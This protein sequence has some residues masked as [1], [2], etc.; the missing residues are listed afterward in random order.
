MLRPQVINLWLR[1]TPLLNKKG[2]S[3]DPQTDPYP[4]SRKL[5]LM[6]LLIILAIRLNYHTFLQK[7]MKSSFIMS[8]CNNE[9]QQRLVCIITKL[10]KV[11]FY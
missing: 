6:L 5:R 9:K 8:L 11:Y 4:W 3:E 1:Y 7:L 10:I 2:M